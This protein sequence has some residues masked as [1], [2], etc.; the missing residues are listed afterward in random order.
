MELRIYLRTL[1]KKWWI[2]FVIFLLVFTPTVWFTFNQTPVYEATAAYLVVPRV[3]EVGKTISIF[4]LLSSRSEL[5]STYAE[6]ASSHTVKHSAA[7]VLGIPENERQDILIESKLLPGT[8]VLNVTVQGNNPRLVRDFTNQVGVETLRMVEDLYETFSLEPLD[9]ARIPQS[10]VRPNIPLNLA[11][12]AVFGLVL[13]IGTAFFAVYLETSTD[14]V[15]SFGIIDK[16]TGVYNKRY[17]T[18]RVAEEMSRAR[19]NGYPLSLAL[20]NVD[21]LGVINNSPPQ[22]RAEALRRVSLLLK[23]YLREEDVMAHFGKGV[24]SF[25]LPDMSGV[26]ARETMEKLQARIAWTPLELENS[27]V[28]LNLSSTAG[29]VAYQLD[30]TSQDELLARATQAL[31][32]AE[33]AGFGKVELVDTSNGRY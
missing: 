17:F 16:E 12:G 25:M 22:V 20:M 7:D 21:H 4:N 33:V 13:G 32:E 23:Q 15:G 5:A 30:N 3:A 9:L 14:Q 27:G 19:R 8:I 24:F 28:K 26:S 18:Q 29:V 6:V 1:V 2:V 11:L 10:A 31:E